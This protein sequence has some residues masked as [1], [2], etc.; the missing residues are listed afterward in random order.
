MKGKER[1][2]EFSKFKFHKNYKISHPSD[3]HFYPF[4]VAVGCAGEA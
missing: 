2:E 1:L 4:V 3:E